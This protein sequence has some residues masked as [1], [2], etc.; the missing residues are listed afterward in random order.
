MCISSQLVFKWMKYLRACPSPNI[1]CWLRHSAERPWWMPASFFQE[2]WRQCRW[3]WTVWKSDLDRRRRC[4]KTLVVT[5]LKKMAR[6]RTYP[7]HSPVSV[8]EGRRGGE[9]AAAG[10]RWQSVCVWGDGWGRLTAESGSVA[11]RRWTLTRLTD[12]PGSADGAVV[13]ADGVRRC[14]SSSHCH[15]HSEVPSSTFLWKL[16]KTNYCLNPTITGQLKCM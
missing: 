13:H 16:G 12:T 4:S 6:Y 15:S 5:D 14:V 2:Q 11:E 1:A 9:A 10:D 3:R 7:V 8:G